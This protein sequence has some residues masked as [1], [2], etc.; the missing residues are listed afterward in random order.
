MI[1]NA[2]IQTIVYLSGYA[3]S[4]SE[5]ML[6]EAGVTLRRLEHQAPEPSGQREGSDEVPFLR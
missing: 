2:G 6:R 5:A 3:D 1:I 4:M